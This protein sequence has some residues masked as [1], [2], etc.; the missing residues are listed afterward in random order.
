MLVTKSGIVTDVRFLQFSK[1]CCPI[2]VI[3][4]GI[5]I[6]SIFSFPLKE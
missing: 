4:S 2:F 3:V 1:A 6:D 5:V